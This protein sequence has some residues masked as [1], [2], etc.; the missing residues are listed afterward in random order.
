MTVVIQLLTV[1]VCP[2]TTDEALSQT[3]VALLA[4]KDPSY[5][6]FVLKII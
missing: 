3:A 2:E 5:D 1:H 4:A 6:V